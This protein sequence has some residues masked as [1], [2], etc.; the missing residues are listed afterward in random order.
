M[1]IKVQSIEQLQ[2]YFAGVVTR[3]HHAPGVN[4]IIYPILG[5]IVLKLDPNSEIEVRSYSDAPGNML[6]VHINGTRYAFRYDHDDDTIEIRNNNYKG[7]ILHRI[8]N[9]ST[10]SDLKTIFD[11]L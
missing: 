4:E 2:R 7:A 10:I 11:S 9:H 3:S 6:W 5:L 8:N 1:S